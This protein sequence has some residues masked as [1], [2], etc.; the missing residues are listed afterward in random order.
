MKIYNSLNID[1]ACRSV[2]LGYFDAVHLGHRQV[3]KSA[4][5]YALQHQLEGTVFTFS[6]SSE[7]TVKGKEILQPAE[8]QSRIESL[9][10]DSF[11][12][13]PFSSFFG[14]SPQQFAVDILHKALNAKAVFCGSN[15]TFGAK[16]AGNPLLLQQLCAPLGIKV[17]VAG[18]QGQDGEDISSTRIRK[19]LE[20]GQV[21]VA[22]RLMGQLYS[23]AL[24]VVHGKALGKTIGVPTINQI[25]TDNMQMPKS[26]V[27]ATRVLING[28]YYA[29]ATGIGSR[30]TV[31]G[32]GVT[33]ETFIT[34][35]DGDLYGQKIRIEFLQFLLETKKYN[36]LDELKAC[37]LQ[38]AETSQK[39]NSV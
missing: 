39:L 37:I 18:L 31:G 5:Q 16:K 33:C 17:F 34:G 4:V 29:G 26:G 6:L 3:I 15:Y 14:M 28:K 20:N 9:G 21:D 10:I 1:S 22:A 19:H 38:A 36:S 11:I 24:P 27:Y 8:K 7:L 25:Y 32:K 12:C 2:A 35:F 13:P 30:P 23:I